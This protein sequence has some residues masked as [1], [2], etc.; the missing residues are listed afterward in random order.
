MNSADTFVLITLALLAVAYC[1]VLFIIARIMGLNHLDEDLDVDELEAAE[2]P[3]PP[4]YLRNPGW[5]SG[6]RDRLHARRHLIDHAGEDT[7]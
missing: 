6:L 4:L 5:R 1:G 7:Q 2:H 3:H